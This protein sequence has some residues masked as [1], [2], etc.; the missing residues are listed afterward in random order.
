M[1]PTVKAKSVVGRVASKDDKQKNVRL[2]L[3]TFSYVG[4]VV[5]VTCSY[6]TKGMT[7]VEE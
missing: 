5:S 2:A 1:R 7:D 4:V 6:V 3:A